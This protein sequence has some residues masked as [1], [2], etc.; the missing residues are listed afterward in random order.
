MEGSVA[1][2]LRAKVLRFF[3][4]ARAADR[5]EVDRFF[6]PICHLVDRRP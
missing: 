5:D 3:A 1:L 6:M 2:R 4:V